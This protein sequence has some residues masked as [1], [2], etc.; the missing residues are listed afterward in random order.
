MPQ[1]IMAYNYGKVGK[2]GTFSILGEG[3]VGVMTLHGSVFEEG[4]TWGSS[5]R[6]G[7]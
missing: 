1:V 5:L 2:S 4:L 6:V 7:V 3:G